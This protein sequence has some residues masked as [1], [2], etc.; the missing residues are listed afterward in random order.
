MS[1]QSEVLMKMNIYEKDNNK[2]F[3]FWYVLDVQSNDQHDQHEGL[4][5]W[6]CSY[7]I[8]SLTHSEVTTMHKR[9]LRVMKTWKGAQVSPTHAFRKAKKNLFWSITHSYAFQIQLFPSSY[10]FSP[11]PFSIRSVKICEHASSIKSVGWSMMKLAECFWLILINFGMSEMR[12]EPRVHGSSRHHWWYVE[13]WI[14]FVHLCSKASQQLIP[15]TLTAIRLR[16]AKWFH[17]GPPFF[18]PAPQLW[19]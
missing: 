19:P 1:P 18:V 14:A 11:L 17:L 5:A 15:A 16:S 6:Y 4:P 10:P 2:Y 8:G 3:M 9:C 12:Q 7:L 13:A